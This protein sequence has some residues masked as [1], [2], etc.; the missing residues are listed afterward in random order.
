MEAYLLLVS[1][2]P[3]QDFIASARRCQDLWYGSWLLSELSR[4]TAKAIQDA[5]S[6][7]AET[8][9]EAPLIFP[10]SNLDGDDGKPSVA[11]KILALVRGPRSYLEDVAETGVHAMEVRLEELAEEAFDRVAAR[12]PDHY[13]HLALARKQVDEM[14]EYLW[15]AAPL[16]GDDDQ[17]YEE[18]RREAERALSARKNTRDWGP[19]P[20]HDLAGDG[21]PKSAL[22][23]ARESVVHESAYD[24][25]EPA[26]LRRRYFVRRSERLCGVGM[27]KRVGTDPEVQPDGA[28]RPAFHSTSHMAAAPLLTRIARLGARGE[29]AVAAYFDATQ[30]A[31]VSLRR[32]RIRPGMKAAARIGGL[33]VPRTFQGHDGY[34]FFEDR[35]PELVEESGCSRDQVP[36]LRRA[37]RGC[38]GALGIG[39][40]C[41]YYALLQA[42]GDHMGRAIDALGSMDRQRTLGRALDEFSLGCREIVEDHAGSLIYAGGD[43]V[44][45]LLPLHTVLDCTAKLAGSFSDALRGL[46]L[47]EVTLPTLS[48]GIAITH[49][50]SPMRD[51]LELVRATERVAKDDAGRNALAIAVSKRSG[52]T[53]S[54]F[55]R[56]SEPNPLHERLAKWRD[57]FSA[58]EIPAKFAHE[59]E[60]AVAPFEVQSGP[61]PDPKAVADA[62]AGL[63]A[64][65]LGRRRARHGEAPVARAAQD[66]VRAR[67]TA[68]DNPLSAARALAAELQ[69][70]RLL[71]DAHR[72]AFGGEATE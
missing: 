68:G 12:D 50:L 19:V 33:D 39:V 46:S 45:A 29:R 26:V 4:T 22:D 36:E 24:R 43:D 42:D 40:P 47:S 8:N 52:G 59:L 23:G 49:H 17:A 72:I 34:V 31:G 60:Q 3:V 62:L 41:P 6:S 27:M 11:N 10:A 66:E 13:F 56:W 20:W 55:G 64:R 44:L 58:D 28:G 5:A 9:D 7:L 65:A 57:F 30:A 38:L 69:V 67:L 16:S 53:L 37:L 63:A 61:D 70:A 18:A 71:R 1:L 51:A 35:L 14:M 54:I 21:V 25:L 32:H 2:G 15:V 48:A